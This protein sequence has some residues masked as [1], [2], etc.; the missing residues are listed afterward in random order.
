MKGFIDMVF[1]HDGRFYLADWKSNFLGNRK[2]QYHRDRLTEAML[3][4]HYLLQYHL[5]VMALHRYLL[6]RQP[7]YDYHCH[8]GGV[9]YLFLRGM[10]PAWGADYGVYCD[11]PEKELVERLC[12]EMIETG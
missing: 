2:E 7:D 4:H 6:L 12:S 8:F 3:E 10:E 5:Y 9:Y 1:E 11:R